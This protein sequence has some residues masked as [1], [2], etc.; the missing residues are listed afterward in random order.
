MRSSYFGLLFVHTSLSACCVEWPHGTCPCSS[1]VWKLLQGRGVLLLNFSHLANARWVRFRV[2]FTGTAMNLLVSGA[3]VKRKQRE[4]KGSFQMVAS[5]STL[6]GHVSWDVSPQGHT[7]ELKES[8]SVNKETIVTKIPLYCRKH[9]RKSSAVL[10]QN[11]EKLR[12]L[13]SVFSRG[14]DYLK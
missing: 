13:T 11:L 2:T 12:K 8:T 5:R 7:E 4:N 10:R 6:Q 14:M 1:L 3:K 9:T